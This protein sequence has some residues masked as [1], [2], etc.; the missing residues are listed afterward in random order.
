MGVRGG[1]S[2]CWERA[3]LRVSNAGSGAVRGRR[4]GRGRDDALP[5]GVVTLGCWSAPAVHGH[6]PCQACM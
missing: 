1:A 2:E 5:A 4:R 3:P 6:R